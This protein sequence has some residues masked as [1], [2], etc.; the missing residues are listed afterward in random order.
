VRFPKKISYH[1]VEAT[2][3]GKKASYPFYRLTYYVAG[4]RVTRS[5]KTYTE[6]KTEAEAKVRD[7]AKGSQAAALTGAQARDTLAAHQR[8]ENF[9]QATG[10]RYSIL[11]AVSEFVEIL[12]KLNGRSPT[13]AIEG[14]LQTV[15][16][17]KPKD[18]EEAVEEFI[19]S[20]KHMAEEQ[21]GKRSQLSPVY[22]KNVASWLREFAATFPATTV[23]DL[24]KDH[25]NLYFK[26]LTEIAAKS[27]ND[28]RAVVKMFLAWATRQDYLNASHRLCEANSMTRETVESGDTDF[29]RPNELQKF[30]D[31]ASK[32]LLPVLAIGGLAGLRGEEI[33]RLDWADVWRVEGH[34]EVSAQQAKTRQRR[35]VQICPALA[36]R[37][38]DYRN[39]TGKVFSA[40][41]YIFQSKFAEL[42]NTLKIPSRRNGLRHAFCTYHFALNA[43]E[44][45]TAQQAGNS[46]T[47]IHAHYKGLATKVEAEKWFGL[48]QTKSPKYEKEIT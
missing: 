37:L 12:E 11:G 41:V 29:F 9:R 45:L 14:F 18:V 46:P 36:H 24:T 47:M 19:A 1:K 17:V 32:D 8:L 26:P 3:Y 28:R 6:A 33:M 20:R 31:N 16:T 27:R 44:N 15:A 5:F 34:I 39:S 48:Q 40:G 4:K 23:C 13:E 43:N 42:R 21:N 22:A 30:L 7:I 25:I 2:I 10:R 38:E 35:L